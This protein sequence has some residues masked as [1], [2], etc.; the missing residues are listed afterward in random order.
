M[1]LLAKLL[2]ALVA[3]LLLGALVA[4]LVRMPQYLWRI[5][6]V[7]YVAILPAIG[8]YPP[9]EA[10]RL[11]IDLSGGTI[12]V[13]QVKHT[14]PNFSIDKMVTALNKRINPTGVVDVT[15]RGIGRDRVEI[16]IPR[17]AQ[18]EV[19]RCKR[20]LTTVGSLEFRILAN[21]R[22]HA[23]LIAQAKATFPRPVMSGEKIQARWV[24]IDQ[25]S[26]SDFGPHGG[27][28]VQTNPADGRMYA[29]VY[30]DV[31]NVKGDDLSRTGVTEERGQPAVS[32]HFNAAGASRFG[33]LT[34]KFAPEPDGSFERRLAVIL[35]G[36]IYTAPNLHATI[37]SDGVISGHFTQETAQD[38]V[39]V[40]NAGSLP[41]E[42][43]KT[44]AS[45]LTIGP[46]LG[47]D[48]IHSGLMAMAVATVV[49][50]VFMAV[51][52]H[53][54]GLIADIA[55]ILNCLIVVGLMAWMHATWTLAGLAGLALTVGMAVDANVLIYERL[56][57]EQQ[58]GRSLRA[59]IEHA[60]DRA[61]SPI[62][63]SNITT[64]LAGV[65]LYAV[66]SE[67]VKGF[68]VTLIIGLLANL[69]TA[70]FVCR[71]LFD[72]I[73]RNGWVKRM[74]M[75]AI[76][77]KPNFDF[78]GKRY[79]CVGASVVAIVIGLSVLFFRGP[80][81]LDIDFTGGTLAA[82]RFQEPTDSAKVRALA[83]KV[84]PDVSIETLKLLDEKEEGHRFLIRTTLDNPAEVKAKIAEAFGAQLA[85]ITLTPGPINDIPKELPAEKPQGEA[86]AAE[87]GNKAY[88]GGLRTELTMNSPVSLSFLRN[89]LDAAL[90][91]EKVPDP[92]VRYTLTPVGEAAQPSPA[93]P[94]EAAQPEKAEAKSDAPA[95]GKAEASETP[96]EKEYTHVLLETNLDRAQLDKI[97]AGAARRVADLSM[98]ERLENFGGQV[99]NE[100][101]TAAVGA[102]LL[103]MLIMVVYLWIRFQN[104]S[105]GLGAVVAL[106][107]DV[108]VVLGLLAISKYLAGTFLGHL[109]MIEDFKIN[110]PV[111]AALLTLVGYSV[112]DTIVVFD[113]IREVKG[114]R[115][116]VT[117]PLI[118]ES[119]NQTLS[120][121]I[122][123]SLTVL[124]VAIILYVVGGSAIHGFSFCLVAGVIVGTYS[125]IY[126]ASPFL[127]WVG[128]RDPRRTG[129]PADESDA[130]VSGAAGGDQSRRRKRNRG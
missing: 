41:G 88:A 102:V 28:A 27:V 36:E 21:Q 100:M 66:G 62:L 14:E 30:Q 61:L 50:L 130:E 5:A 49:I 115:K 23:A 60:F 38:L 91:D 40:L 83:E 57:E 89:V 56:R 65:V 94:K 35:N 90:S 18:Q 73:E 46:T 9:K 10:M 25:R 129:R 6:L 13:Y 120:R 68:A 43:V 114:K 109:L 16:I 98:F 87:M 95:E 99:A 111:V 103:S 123:T 77:G 26:V 71:L 48:T 24:P 75:L 29:L 1:L 105:Y 63:D 42:L 4:Q 20:I 118:N 113:R 15:I 33:N 31:Y 67:Q 119:V 127:V 64:L 58:R 55:V 110:L 53:L 12:L 93:P 76:F 45:E 80:G 19:E 69:F 32:F 117:W 72:I 116:E 126:I 97:I 112:N 107:H 37:T 106:I 7:M 85:R 124:M 122:L 8:L 104:L 108:S 22:D 59:T 39:A 86:A 74:S 81:I 92:S 2:I 17:A 82:V 11:G 3:P 51:Y 121:T 54:A 44:P 70:V 78:I 47:R 101:Q 125:S 96:A 84:L 79:I 128:A 52:Y 34:A